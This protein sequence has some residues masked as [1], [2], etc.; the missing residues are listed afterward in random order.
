MSVMDPYDENLNE[1]ES[2]VKNKFRW[3][4]LKLLASLDGEQYLL[5]E[6][7]RK[8]NVPGKVMCI[9]CN[10]VITYSAHGQR[11]V[12][13]HVNTKKHAKRG[14]VA[15]G[16]HKDGS[17]SKV[18][19]EVDC[20]VLCPDKGRAAD[21]AVKNRFNPNWLQRIGQAGEYRYRY[22]DCIKKVSKPGQAFCIWCE[23]IIRYGGGGARRLADHFCTKSHV[24]RA[25]FFLGL[26]KEVAEADL[27]KF[28]DDVDQPENSGQLGP[29]EDSLSVLTD[30]ESEDDNEV[31]MEMAGQHVTL[32][33]RA[34]DQE[35]VDLD[36]PEE[37]VKNK[38]NLVEGVNKQ[39]KTK[40]DDLDWLNM[41]NTAT[42]ELPYSY[43]DCL[44]K[45]NVPGKV[46]CIW[47]DMLLSYGAKGQKSITN[48]LKTWR[49]I[50]NALDILR[51][52]SLTS[53]VSAQKTA[54][55]FPCYELDEEEGESVTETG[56]GYTEPHENSNERGVK[57][58][59]FVVESDEESNEPFAELAEA[60]LPSDSA[61]SDLGG[62]VKLEVDDGEGE[63]SGFIGDEDDSYVVEE[64]LVK[65]YYKVIKCQ[66]YVV[67][68]VDRRTGRV[69]WVSSKQKEEEPLATNQRIV[70]H[71]GED[72]R[73]ATPATTGTKK[74]SSAFAMVPSKIQR[75][76]Q[77][78]T[79]RSKTVALTRRKVHGV[80]KSDNAVNRNDLHDQIMV[81]INKDVDSENDE[82]NS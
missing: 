68:K 70:S 4:W 58:R 40:K 17:K 28:V 55:K 19:K 15:R 73:P 77:D 14:L 75:V 56:N 39:K 51:A 64:T 81:Y 36:A 38:V 5:N 22:R 13:E 1:V 80:D 62:D 12:L 43:S 29:G 31:P 49:H 79:G 8:L 34:R 53:S 20:T 24:R 82:G 44:K 41:N 71:S 32:R 61:S 10:V 35:D 25:Q 76:N 54:K 50:N 60:T 18:K 63:P 9:W 47:C 6:C 7:I 27:K 37:S 74:P 3:H 69:I 30:V 11:A 45:V 46:K 72:D 21:S 42:L 78:N 52:K 57:R 59:D 2:S 66:E 48:H 65:E 33:S 16:K 26:G 67:R 23:K